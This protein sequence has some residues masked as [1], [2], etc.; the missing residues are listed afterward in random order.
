MNL[1]LFSEKNYNK[2]APIFNHLL[3]LLAVQIF[4]TGLGTL[5]IIDSFN[6]L[7]LTL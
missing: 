2:Q 6:G 7:I 4:C 1:K 3:V 5:K